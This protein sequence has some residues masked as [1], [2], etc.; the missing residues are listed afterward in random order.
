MVVGHN[1]ESGDI[2]TP[3]PGNPEEIEVILLNHA[4]IGDE[5]RISDMGAYCASMRAKGYNSFPDAPE[6][7]VD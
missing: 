7:M 1:C 2:F 4:E 3:V 6:I 5:V